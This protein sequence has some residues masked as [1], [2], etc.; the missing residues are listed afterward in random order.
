M[1]DPSPT[2]DHLRA[3]IA[4]LEA[5]LATAQQHAHTGERYRLLFT[6]STDAI[7][8]TDDQGNYLDV[9]PA[10]A[11][12]FGLSHTAM[13][14]MNVRDLMILNLPHVDTQYAQYVER[15]HE[16]GELYFTHPSGEQ[17]IAA[18]VASKIG[19]NLHQCILRDVTT[20]RTAEHELRLSETRLRMALDAA[21]L[22]TYDVDLVNRQVT[23]SA[24][25]APL[26]GGGDQPLQL[27]IEALV[28]ALHPADRHYA[29]ERL[30]TFIANPESRGI[31]LRVLQPNGASVWLRGQGTLLHAQDGTPARIVGVLTNCTQERHAQALLAQNS[32]DLERRVFERTLSLQTISQQLALAN[33]E[34]QQQRNLLQTILDSLADGVALVD[35]TGIIRTINRAWGLICGVDP[36]TCVGT[37]WIMRC[38]FASHA[39]ANAILSGTQYRGRETIQRDNQE[40]MVDV[41]VVPLPTSQGSWQVVVHIADVTEQIRFQ[42][43]AIQNERLTATG[44]LAAVIAH[45][46][47]SPLQAIQNFLFLANSDDQRIRTHHLRL[48]AE[49]IDRIGGLIRRLLDLQRPQNA[50]SHVFDLH[51]TIQRVLT[52][53]SGTLNRNRVHVQTMF[54]YE[55]L[56]VFGR[57][58]EI[59]QVLLN[60]VLNALDEMPHGGTITIRTA[61]YQPAHEPFSPAAMI[62]ITDTG[63]GVDPAL[64]AQIF[65][66]FF[67]TKTSGSGLGLAI[68]HQIIAQHN[69]RMLARNANPNGAIFQIILPFSEPDLEGS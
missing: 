32:S 49:E 19:P 30:Q 5:Q 3:R 29:L 34:L 37:L 43:I 38:P 42:S 24:R 50:T 51:T 52:L 23:I 65:D 53:T 10:A 28:H 36:L 66:P 33:A 27:S 15:G 44:R 45:E 18:Y 4:E 11:Q 25:Y 31:E 55:P 60:I 13:L 6:H 9:N 22:G 26:F 1:I 47:N 35:A 58:D 57:S 20:A 46:V 61:R 62:E 59:T 56:W 48:I 54:T 17:R 2:T 40:R 64:L 12:L 16:T 63:P 8:I 68:S 14:S 67:T 21:H 41:Q 7:L 39:I 69:G